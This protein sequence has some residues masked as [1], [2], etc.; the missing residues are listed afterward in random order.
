[1]DIENDYN[2]SFATDVIGVAMVFAIPVIA[3][4]II[5]II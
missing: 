4:A 3:L 1:M 2:P 5:W